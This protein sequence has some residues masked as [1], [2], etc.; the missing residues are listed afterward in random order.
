MIQYSAVCLVVG[1]VSIKQ[2]MPLETILTLTKVTIIKK[3][4]WSR[5]F[6]D[7]INLSNKKSSV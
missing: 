6:Y 5:P 7:Y 1:A 4:G 3:A 2:Y